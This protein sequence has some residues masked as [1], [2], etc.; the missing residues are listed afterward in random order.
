M[1]GFVYLW[2]NKVTGH[3]Y[4]GRH[5]GDPQSPYKGSGRYFTRAYKKYGADNFERIILEHVEDGVCIKQ[6]EQY[7]LD[8]FNAA[9]NPEF[10]NISPN[11]HGGHHGADYA[12]PKNPMF[13]KRHPNHRPHY[14]KENGM[15]GIHRF[16]S[17]NPNSKPVRITDADGNVYHGSCLKECIKMHGLDIKYSKAT[18][19]ARRG[20]LIKKGPYKGWK[21]EYVS[22]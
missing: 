12:G 20:H 5:S 16:G 10:Y 3:K 15:Y 17:T 18:H 14:G 11:S 8:L 19:Y 9:E 7:Y 6:R 21:F 1:A 22:I 4:I 13:G 2:V